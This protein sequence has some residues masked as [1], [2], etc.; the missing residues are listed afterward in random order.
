MNSF[1]KRGF[2][3]PF[4]TQHSEYRI[5]LG[6]RAIQIVLEALGHP[7]RSFRTVHVAGTNGKGSVA[8]MI[9]SCLAEC[10]YRTGLFT[11]PHIRTVRERFRINHEM[12]TDAEL[13][14]ILDEIQAVYDDLIK[15]DKIDFLT[16]FEI[17]T[18]VSF[19]YFKKYHV[20]IAVIE[21]GMG[22]RLDSTNVIFSPYIAL[23]TIGF[24]HTAYLGSTLKKIALEKASVIHGEADVVLGVLP[25][26]VKKAVREYASEARFYCFSKDFTIR[27]LKNGLLCYRSHGCLNG[28]NFKLHL[29][30]RH[31]HAN[32]ATALKMLEILSKD[33]FC[34]DQNKIMGC[35]SAIRW[36]G[37]L[38]VISQEPLVIL[39]AAH[40]PQGMKALMDSL[41]DLFPLVEFVCI[42]GFCRD[43]DYIRMLDILGKRCR[44]IYLVPLDNPRGVVPVEAADKAIE[45][46]PS[47]KGKLK[48]HSDFRSALSEIQDKKKDRS[49]LVCGS[50]FLLEKAYNHFEDSLTR[51]SHRVSSRG[52]EKQ[53]D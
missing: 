1:A 11:S 15:Q 4:L 28:L 10:G 25:A 8:H 30:G 18:I 52:R 7:E 17:N 49:L 36:K 26:H 13:K 37:R 24:D 19:I 9:A 47:L 50:F 35:L 45:N 41:K 38:D 2:N 20:D 39:D 43:K 34:L 3:H 44:K 21:V 29:L 31:Q 16:F 5:R 42:C 6:L 51:I 12:I 46:H 14:R 23:T 22:G 53:M 40:N 33:G 48:C 32:C 27:S